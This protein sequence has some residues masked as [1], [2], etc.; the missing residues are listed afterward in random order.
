MPRQTIL[1]SL[2]RFFAILLPLAGLAT[3]RA[4]EPK[5]SPHNRPV[6]ISPGEKV[7]VSVFGIQAKGSKFVF[8]VDRSGSTDGGALAA[9]KAELLH[10]IEPI[11]DRQQFQII[12]YN[13]KPKIFNPTGTPGKLAFGT[14]ENKAEV[15]KFLSGIEA[16]GGTDHEAAL[17]LAM[18]LHPDV[19]FL[20][21]DGDDP[22]L[23]AR[24]L[25]RIDRIGPGVVINTVQ[26][27]N[28]P[29]TKKDHFL[30]K[31]AKQSGGEFKYVD[32]KASK[33]DK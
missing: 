31:L 1:R 32:L 26:F 3:T 22:Q 6:V 18:K 12:L 25:D 8:V 15:R 4:E 24:Q 20:F 13:E 19:V 28:G 10:G 17:A 7:E 2:P 30:G 11:N 23:S 5:T 33:S 29:Q 9:S 14:D 21:T 16:D 27:G